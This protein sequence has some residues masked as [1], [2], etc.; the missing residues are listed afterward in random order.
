MQFDTAQG[1]RIGRNS[2]TQEPKTAT[3]SLKHCNTITEGLGGVVWRGPGWSGVLGYSNSS[4]R[5]LKR[6]DNGIVKQ[7]FVPYVMTKVAIVRFRCSDFFGL[8]DCTC[9]GLERVDLKLRRKAIEELLGELVQTAGYRS[10][11]R[12]WKIPRSLEIMKT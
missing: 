4:R 8:S 5:L 9:F 7:R 12:G 11:K 1:P 6:F 2:I 10:Q 3:S